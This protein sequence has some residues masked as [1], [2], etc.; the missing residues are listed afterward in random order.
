MARHSCWIFRKCSNPPPKQPGMAT[1][2]SA[3]S[4]H[5]VTRKHTHVPTHAS[6]GAGAMCTFVRRDNME[7]ATVLWYTGAKHGCK[8]LYGQCYWGSEAEA[9]QR[10]SSWDLCSALYC[11]ARHNAGTYVCYARMGNAATPESGDTVGFEKDCSGTYCNVSPRPA[12]Y[13][14]GTCDCFRMSKLV[15]VTPSAMGQKMQVGGLWGVC[16]MCE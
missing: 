3:G 5:S 9:K 4:P 13:V 1:G 12:V 16:P 6:Y 11:T 10:C 2:S 15:R 14:I 7:P 8:T